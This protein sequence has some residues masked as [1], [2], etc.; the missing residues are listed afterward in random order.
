MV[1]VNPW[2]DFFLDDPVS[3]ANRDAA[4]EVMRKYSQH[5]FWF[6]TK[7]PDNITSM[8]PPYWPLRNVW[9]GV[10][11]E[12]QHWADKRMNILRNIPIHPDALRFV[13]AEPLLSTIQFS[14]PSSLNKYGWVLAGGER[15]NRKHPPR[16]D[17]QLDQWFLDIAMQCKNAGVP[18]HLMQRGGVSKCGCHRKKN[19]TAPKSPYHE[20]AYGC[21]VIQGRTFD[22]FP[23]QVQVVQGCP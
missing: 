11:C 16:L 7:H 18:F 23:P 21:R 10:S 4:W 19:P 1:F 2:S 3:N 9:L 20:P 17:P 13:M 22:E 12:N 5:I 6:P 14:G 15:G 8:L